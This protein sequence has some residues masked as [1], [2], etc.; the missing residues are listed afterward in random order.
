MGRAGLAFL[1]LYANQ[2]LEYQ[3]APV[4]DRQIRMAGRLKCC[5][6]QEIA[7]RIQ[8]NDSREM[9]TL[10]SKNHATRW[11]TLQK[12]AAGLDAAPHQYVSVEL[13]V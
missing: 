9:P 1:G 5:Q 8:E 4:L 7:N 13:F 2:L 10:E 6:N 12:M 3:I 11:R